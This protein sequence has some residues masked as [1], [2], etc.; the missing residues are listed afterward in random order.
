MVTTTLP[1][2]D[3]MDFQLAD[4]FEAG[5]RAI[6]DRLA[7]AWGGGPTGD[8]E[9]TYD[10]LDRAANQV[11]RLLTDHGVSAQDRVGVHGY[12]HASFIVVTLACFKLAAVPINASYRYTATELA[13]VFADAGVQVVVTEPELRDVVA[14]ASALMP[15]DLES[16]ITFGDELDAAA[17]ALEDAPLTVTGRSG[18]NRYILYTGGTTGMPKGVVWR[19][20]DIFFGALGGDGV[21]RQGFPALTDPA[22]AGAWA[23]AGNPVR[24]RMPLCP[25]IHG[26]AQWVALTTILSGGTLVLA[27][28]RSFDAATAWRL[29]DRFD[30]EL[31]MVIGDAVARPL[32]DALPAGHTAFPALR[33][34]SSSG[35]PLSAR[36]RVELTEALGDVR[37]LDRYGASETGGHGRLLEPDGSGRLRLRGDATTAVLDD[38]GHVI[39][40]GSRTVGRLARRGHIPLEYWNDPAK[41]AT[42]F[43][44][45]DGQRWAV[46]G[47]LATVESDGTIVVLGR[48]SI[49]INSGGEKIFPEEVE[50]VIK[51][52]APV[53][54][55][56]VVGLPDD[57][58]GQRVVAVISLRGKSATRPAA[59]AALPSLAPDDLV[60]ELIA[61]C[62]QQLAGYKIPKRFVIVD[63]VERKITGKADYDWARR[64]ATG[65]LVE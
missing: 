9:L 61:H 35:A 29:A 21:P 50:N 31:I 51:A 26:G 10:A 65:T 3:T 32:L 40:P 47:D 59:S 60:A 52:F 54:D 56:L 1:W 11:A 45:Y 43:P 15:H 46:P 38:E 22:D 36:M 53:Q 5:A 44:I 58:F 39:S 6:P 55:C 2:G 57:R 41:T 25:L 34:I 33:F 14:D 17:T 18:D 8:G 12:N 37:I 30:V 19:H 63:A 28:D 23:S 64:V 42:T 13:Y 20:E 24:V 16:I 7:L 62:R 49:V 48:G 4:I 27:T